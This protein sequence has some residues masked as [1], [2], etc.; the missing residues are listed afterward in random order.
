MSDDLD[1]VSLRER[2]VQWRAERG[3]SQ[4][5]LARRANVPHQL[6]NRLETGERVTLTL[7][8]AIKLAHALG[9]SMNA[10]SGLGEEPDEEYTPAGEVVMG[11]VAS[12]DGS[13]E[14]TNVYPIAMSVNNGQAS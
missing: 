1:P 5:E 13:T 8:N 14:Y 12:P 2:L 6:V 9:I 11:V 10:L 7:E 4:R 3:W